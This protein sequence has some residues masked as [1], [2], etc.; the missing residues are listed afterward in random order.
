MRG[1]TQRCVNDHENVDCTFLSRTATIRPTDA[2]VY[3]SLCDPRA[4]DFQ[5]VM[6]FWKL[7]K[8]S[9]EHGEDAHQAKG[10]FSQEGRQQRA[11]L[12]TQ[13][14]VDEGHTWER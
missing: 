10:A 5:S 13:V 7:G 9:G 12:P 4:N 2:H 8:R 6:A 14:V 1:R 11:L 3:P